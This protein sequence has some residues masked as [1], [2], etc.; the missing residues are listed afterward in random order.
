MPFACLRHF[1]AISAADPRRFCL[2]LSCHVCHAFLMFIY[3]F[4]SYGRMSRC[5]ATRYGALSPIFMRYAYIY[6]GVF[7]YAATPCCLPPSFHFSP[8]Y[9]IFQY[10]MSLLLFRYDVTHAA[11]MLRR[12]RDIT[13][14]L[15]YER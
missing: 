8:C 3:R 13:L 14:L 2:M 10:L 7:R 4:A 9:D 11:D 1:V 5:H 6:H 12:L 15:C